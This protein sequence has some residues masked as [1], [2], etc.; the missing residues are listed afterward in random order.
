MN[1][2]FLVL[3]ALL[4]ACVSVTVVAQQSPIASLPW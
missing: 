3:T 4:L 1:K 2:F